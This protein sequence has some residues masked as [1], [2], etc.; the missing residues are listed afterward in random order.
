MGIINFIFLY[1]TVQKFGWDPKRSKSCLYNISMVLYK[2]FENL[3]FLLSL[4]VEERKKKRYAEMK[5]AGSKIFNLVEECRQY[6]KADEN[7]EIW[8]AVIIELKV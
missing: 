7:A 2:I 6:F 3:I 8:K 5:E 1:Q 4:D